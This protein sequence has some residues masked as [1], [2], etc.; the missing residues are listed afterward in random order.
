MGMLALQ[1][2]RGRPAKSGPL[3]VD[4]F[5]VIHRPILVVGASKKAGTAR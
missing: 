4:N 3:P 5:E 1:D 2:A